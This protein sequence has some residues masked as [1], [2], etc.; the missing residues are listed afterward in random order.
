MSKYTIFYW[1]SLLFTRFIKLFCDYFCILWFNYLSLKTICD[2]SSIQSFKFGMCFQYFDSLWNS[3]ITKFSYTCVDTRN[4]YTDFGIGK[5]KSMSIVLSKAAKSTSRFCIYILR[6][7][8]TVD[9]EF[10]YSHNNI[11]R[12]SCNSNLRRFSNNCSL[13]FV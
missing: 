12:I 11:G 4:L 8:D 2:L 3:K 5:S 13:Q 9:F 1:F 7:E 6:F 10:T